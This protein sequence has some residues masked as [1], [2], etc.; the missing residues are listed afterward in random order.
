MALGPTSYL[1]IIGPDPE[2]PKPSGPR[3]FG[4]DDLKAP[5]IVRW[6]VKSSELAA[7]AE[8]ADKA[9]VTLGADRVRQ[10]PPPD[11]VVLAWRYTDPAVVVA[12]GLVPFFI[13][14]GSSPHPAL[15]AAKGATLIQL[16]AEHPDAPEGGGGGSARRCSRRSDSICESATSRFLHIT[17]QSSPPSSGQ[18]RDG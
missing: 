3:R 5:R 14:W 1:E 8:K 13:D 10:P 2:Q 6:V 17:P 12:D 4:I 11:G 7:V 15:T 9:G 18:A 16:R